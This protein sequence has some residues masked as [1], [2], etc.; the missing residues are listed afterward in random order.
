MAKGE[1]VAAASCKRCHGMQG[2]GN[3]NTSRAT[4]AKVPHLAT[5]PRNYLVK[6]IAGY[7][8][9]FNWQEDP[10]NVFFIAGMRID[11]TMGMIAEKLNKDEVDAVSLWYHCQK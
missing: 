7:V 2:R 10:E 9:G 1:A 11:D 4:Q 5:Q 6:A 8:T 3:P